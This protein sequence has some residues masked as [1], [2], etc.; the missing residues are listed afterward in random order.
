[1]KKINTNIL[2]NFTSQG[3]L[4]LIPLLAYPQIAGI[5][6]EV[7]FTKYL[8]LISIVSLLSLFIRYGFDI[9]IIKVINGKKRSDLYRDKLYSA[10]T[11]VRLFIYAISSLFIYI[12]ICIYKEESVSLFFAL[13]FSG[14]GFVISKNFLYVSSQ[15]FLAITI[16][17]IVS[18]IIFLAILVLPFAITLSLDWIILLNSIFITTPFLFLYALDKTRFTTKL[19]FSYIQTITKD[20][21]K[22]FM[23]NVSKNIN[24]ALIPILAA[25][26]IAMKTVGAIV[27]IM[28]V[29]NVIITLLSSITIAIFP[30]NLQ[31]KKTDYIGYINQFKLYLR[32]S[33]SLSLFIILLAYFSSEYIV[34]FISND[35]IG[36]DKKLFLAFII[37][38]P[39]GII[40]NFTCIQFLIPH[41]Y[42]NY[43]NYLVSLSNIIGLIVILILYQYINEYAPAIGL[44]IIEITI[45]YFSFKKIREVGNE[46]LLDRIF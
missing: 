7:E 37:S 26:F 29:R 34:S 24:T 6:G 28:L 43:V 16:S 35:T 22:Y 39:I 14:I 45:L 4:Y 10:T 36:L 15:R 12:L 30:D 8:Y 38:I 19:R 23:A 17:T 25:E 21:S 31:L 5:L 42:K 11:I 46:N 2:L 20:A 1:M 13:V 9:S 18:K 41:N 3:F 40:N 33:V 27:I 32:I 44:L